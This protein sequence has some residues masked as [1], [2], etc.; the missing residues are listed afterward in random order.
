MAEEV[1]MTQ[2]YGYIILLQ[3]NCETSV[4]YNFKTGKQYIKV[5]QWLHLW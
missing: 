4:R 3:D 2:G 5:Y 1:D